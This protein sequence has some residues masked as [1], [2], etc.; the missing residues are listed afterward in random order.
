[1][2]AALISVWALLVGISL[3]MM[4]S[5]LQGSLL[6][7]RAAAEGFSP[8]QTGI[9]MS[10][11]YAGFILVSVTAPRLI[12]NVGHIRVFGALAST[13]STAAL[14]HSVF[15]EPAVWSVLRILTG[16]CY[17]GLFV[18]AESWLNDRASNTT[19]GQL[20]SLYMTVMTGAMAAGPLLLNIAPTAGYELFIVASIL[21]SVALVPVALTTYPAPRFEEQD[22]FGLRELASISPLG[23]AGCLINGAST[24]ALIWLASHYGKLTGMGIEE[25]SVFTA[26]SIV[27]GTILIWPT[28]RLSDRFDR[29][30]VI[31]GIALFGSV[32][33]ALSAMFTSATAIAGIVAVAIVGGFS[34]PLYSLAVAHTNDYLKPR[35]TVAA[36][37]GLLLVNGLGGMAGPAVAG[38]IIQVIGPSGYFWFPAAAMLSLG[39][40]AVYRMKKRPAVPNERQRDFVGMLRTSGMFARIALRHRLERERASGQT[41]A[42]GAPAQ[43]GADEDDRAAQ[44]TEAFPG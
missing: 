1:M 2:I 19:R 43:A 10:S 15:V 33:A 44:R 28:G 22:R 9:V 5:G 16:F 21:V 27:G 41:P 20:L 6:G 42:H 25:I 30:L 7:V 26:A 34:M 8:V 37:S 23:V 29:R 12:R 18:T 24:G 38:G 31:T 13:A 4:G 17:I 32:S 39:I 11:Y 14:L 40:F 3:L 35:Q 36:S